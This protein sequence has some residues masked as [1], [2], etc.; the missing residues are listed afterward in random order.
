MWKSFNEVVNRESCIVNRENQQLCG[1]FMLNDSRTTMHEPRLTKPVIGLIGGIGSG[2][3]R[4]AALFR[5]RGARVI[6]G[7]DLGHE[8][9]RQ[10]PVRAQI[11]ARWGR[12]VLDAHGEI[13]RRRLAAIVFADPEQ[14]R[15]LESM[16]HPWI[17]QRMRDEVEQARNDAAARFVVVD[18]AI[19]LEAG[20]NDLCDRLVFVEAPREV[21]RQRIAEQRGWTA[22]E[23]EARE[24]AQ[25]PLTAKAVRADY[26]LHN[27]GSMESLK[28]KVNDL[29]QLWGL[30]S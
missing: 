24:Q 5:E 10:P 12:E 28:Q 7:D 22:E 18:A 11:T 4:V 8:A 23:V 2:K 26:T 16:V 3:S 29:L 20:W 19:L 21:R 9:L 14:R 30:S 15:A 6:A 25:L 17:K 13:N 1:S 27:A